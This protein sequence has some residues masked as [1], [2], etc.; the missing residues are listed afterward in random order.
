MNC[1][2]C[3]KVTDAVDKECCVIKAA[4][5]DAAWEY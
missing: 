1:A 2:P 5:F 4:M 3:W